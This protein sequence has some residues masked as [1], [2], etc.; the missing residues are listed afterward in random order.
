MVYAFPSSQPCTDTFSKLPLA[1]SGAEV[2]CQ[3]PL[4][5]FCC[6]PSTKSLFLSL[7]L[8]H[9]VPSGRMSSKTISPFSSAEVTSVMWYKSVWSLTS[10]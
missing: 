4:Y 6:T 10:A 7:P 3:P 9:A 5:Q 2:I 1:A 8:P